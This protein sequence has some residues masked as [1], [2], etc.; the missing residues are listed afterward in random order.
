M[1]DSCRKR[2]LPPSVF[3]AWIYWQMLGMA[4]IPSS[5]SL[6]ENVYPQILFLPAHAVE[7]ASPAEAVA[8]EQK[9]VELLDRPAR[10]ELD[11]NQV[12]T[13]PW[14]AD[15]FSAIAQIRDLA[16]SLQ[17]E[18]DNLH[19]AGKHDEAARFELAILKLGAV[20]WQ[21]G[22][23]IRALTGIA[24]EGVGTALLAKYRDEYSK[25]VTQQIIAEMAKL[26]QARD[27]PAV[28]M[29]HDRAFENVAW[30]WRP[31][32]QWAINRLFFGQSFEGLAGPQSDAD[33]GGLSAAGGQRATIAGRPSD[34]PLLR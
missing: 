32:L 13:D 8:I 28:V 26:D 29:A 10:V 7:Q 22:L 24:I 11:W 23:V 4:E 12:A 30:R 18:A 34:S 1:A 3:L 5:P 25:P 9:V 2:L 19:L 15:D 20:H 16:R 17:A 27:E 33:C 6:S 21:G 14:A 31:R